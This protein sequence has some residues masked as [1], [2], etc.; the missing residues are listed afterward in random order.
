MC[1]IFLSTYRARTCPT[2]YKIC[3]DTSQIQRHQASKIRRE[4]ASRGYRPV[5]SE[6]QAPSLFLLRYQTTMVIAKYN[7]K[8]EHRSMGMRCRDWWIRGLRNGCLKNHSKKKKKKLLK[9][10]T[11]F[12]QMTWIH[13]PLP[14]VASLL[15]F[16]I[17]YWL[18]VI[19][20]RRRTEGYQEPH[21]Q[22]PNWE[23]GSQHLCW[24]VWW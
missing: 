3:P 11:N 15:L 22:P 9:Y 7:L 5:E 23:V 24:W 20:E 16:D 14:T 12:G 17:I 13:S 19:V 6:Y 1:L 8:W 10:N 18:D 21:A 4:N 2:K